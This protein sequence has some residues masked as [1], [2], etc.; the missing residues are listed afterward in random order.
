LYRAESLKEPRADGRLRRQPEVIPKA[1]VNDLL[2][3]ELADLRGPNFSNPNC[4]AALQAA[5][6]ASRGCRSS[7]ASF[8]VGFSWILA[9]N[10]IVQI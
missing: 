9:T 6:H 3:V 7:F 5:L 4:D 1:P 2:Q 8:F 10:F